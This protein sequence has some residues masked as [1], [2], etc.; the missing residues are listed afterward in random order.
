MQNQYAVIG[1]PIAQSKGLEVFAMFAEQT[2]KPID[3]IKIETELGNFTK[4]FDGLGMMVAWRTTK[5]AAGDWP[6]FRA[7]ELSMK[8]LVRHD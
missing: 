4:Y 5:Y 3:Y 8:E 7:I 1:N 2:G 6:F